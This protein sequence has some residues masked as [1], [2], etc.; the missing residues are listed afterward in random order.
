MRIFPLEHAV[1]NRWKPRKITD[2]CIRWEWP[3]ARTLYTRYHL[4]ADT[5][6]GSE[7]EKHAV[8]SYEA[9]Q[10]DITFTTAPFPKKCEITGHPLVR[11]SIGLREKDGSKPSE[12]DLFVTIRHLDVDNKEI[13]YTGAVGDPVPVIRGWLRLSLRKPTTHP[14]ANSKFVPERDYLSSDVSPVEIGRIYT[15][16]VEVWPTSVVLEPGET[17]ALQV[18]SCDTAQSGIFTHNNPDDRNPEH[19]QGWNDI[20]LGP[21]YDNYLV[22]PVI[23]R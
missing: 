16:D 4:R 19:L 7:Q 10:G 1:Q 8:I 22:L 14:T 6:L 18:S 20:H 5:T 12:I 17:L 15:V 3:L 23:P 13:F 9:P 11:I 21:D 2:R